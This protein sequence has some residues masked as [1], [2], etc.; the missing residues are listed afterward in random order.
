[1]LNACGLCTKVEGTHPAGSDPV[2][3]VGGGGDS[4]RGHVEGCYGCRIGIAAVTGNI[5]PNT[6]EQKT[7]LWQTQTVWYK[8]GLA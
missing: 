2:G 8:A 3:V 7:T 1:M 6:K 5:K 4:V